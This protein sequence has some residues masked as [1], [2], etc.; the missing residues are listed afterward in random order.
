MLLIDAGNTRLEWRR[1]SSAGVTQGASF[2]ED[3]NWPALAD[4]ERIIIAAVS[5]QHRVQA[6]LSVQDASRVQWLT[7]PLIDYPHF[8]HCYAKPQR[9]GVDRWL[10][11]LGARQHSLE[12][13]LVVDAG[14]ALT[15]DLLSAN[16][17]HLGGYIVPGLNLAQHALFSGTDKVRPYADEKVED[18]QAL[19]QDTLSCVHIGLVRQSVG[20]V[21]DVQQQFPQHQLIISGGDGKDLAK[22]LKAPYYRNLVLDGLEQVCAGYLFS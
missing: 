13:L 16:N 9:L 2:Y 3:F 10:A 14:T 4:N 19:G 20:L 12:P 21:R 18:Y 5:A 17:Q 8:Q 1:L 7:Q 22:Q 6:L 11:M 15:I